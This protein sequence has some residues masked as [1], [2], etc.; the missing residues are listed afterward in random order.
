MWIISGFKKKR[1]TSLN[2]AGTTH[3][4]AFTL[5]H[6]SSHSHHHLHV[7]SI[8]SSGFCVINS[9]ANHYLNLLLLVYLQATH[10]L[11]STAEKEWESFW[12]FFSSSLYTFLNDS[13]VK[14]N[15]RFCKARLKNKIT[16]LRIN[17]KQAFCW[18][19]TIDGVTR[20]RQQTIFMKL[21][22]FDRCVS[23]CCKHFINNRLIIP[24][25]AELVFGLIR[26]QY[27]IYFILSSNDHG[28]FVRQEETHLQS[29]GAR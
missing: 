24:S 15:F 14:H 25:I 26:I 19:A 5:R 13:K 9:V 8:A 16:R 2:G 4:P 3:C 10:A 21:H 6:Y 27:Q 7:I 17:S 11:N 18:R 28:Q 1:L 29:D 20:N 23:V 22:F 12:N